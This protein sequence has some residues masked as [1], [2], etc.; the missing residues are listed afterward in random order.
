MKT[1]S[2]QLSE[3]APDLAKRTGNFANDKIDS[4]I[5]TL[6]KKADNAGNHKDR[7]RALFE[8]AVLQAV[9]SDGKKSVDI[10]AGEL[11]ALAEKDAM[12]ARRVLKNIASGFTAQSAPAAEPRAT[13]QPEP[14]PAAG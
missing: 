11:K 10:K 12:E 13:K 5:Q 9:K 2:D 1:L 4:E 7:S 8:I 6:T 3:V 14:T